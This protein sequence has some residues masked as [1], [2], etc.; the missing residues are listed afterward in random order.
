M[1]TTVGRADSYDSIWTIKEADRENLRHY[2]G[3][4]VRCGDKIRLEHSTTGRNLHSHTQY[5]SPISRQAEV[6]GFGYDGEGDGGDDWI[7]ECNT[8]PYYGW[9]GISGDALMGKSLFYLLHQD[10]TTY[11]ETAIAQKF[12][13][14]NCPRCPIIDHLEASGSRKKRAS[15]LWRVH[16]GFFYTER[17]VS[18]AAAQS[19]SYQ[20]I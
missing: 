17:E 14:S 2:S 3:E 4:P 7:I 10:A 8:Q 1:V 18:A 6:S 12:T 20:K 11:L 19:F 16:S 9:T 13:Q 15:G 5:K